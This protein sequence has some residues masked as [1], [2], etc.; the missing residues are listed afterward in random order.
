MNVSY[1]WLKSLVPIDWSPEEL[2]ERLTAVGLSV[3]QVE[4]FNKG[5]KNVVVGEV[6]SVKEHPDE[7]KTKWHVLEVNNGK[8]ILTI[9]CGAPNVAVGIKVALAQV[10]AELPGGINLGAVDKGGVVSNGMLCST[11][12]LQLPEGLAT[13]ESDGGIFILPEECKVGDDLVEALNLDDAIL[14][15]E[16]TPNRADCLSVI[17]IAREVAAISGKPLNLPE[18]KLP[19][20]VKDIKDLA[21]IEVLDNDLCPRYTG[22]L[23]LDVKIGPSPYWMRQRLAAAGIR[24]ISNIVDISNYVMLE[25][26]Q[27]SHTFDYDDIA[28][29]KIIVRRAAKDEKIV[30]LDEA[31]RELDEEML[32]ICDG[33]KAVGI[34]GVMGGLNSEIKDTTKN[35]LIE[36]AYFYPKS[37]RQTY[38]KLGLPSEA[39]SRFEKGIDMEAAERA[40]ERICQLICELAGGTLVD[41]TLDSYQGEFVMPQVSLDYNRCNATL[42]LEIPEPEIDAIIESLDFAYEKIQGGV[43][44]TIPF[45]RQDITREV[46]LIEEVA[47]L[48]GYDKIPTTLP[49][50]TLT[51]GKKTFGQKI[52]DKVKDALTGLG[53]SEIIT[54]SFT[55]KKNYD[56]LTLAQDDE[57]RKSVEVMNPFSDEQGVMRT[58]LLPAILTVASRNMNRKNT[59][60]ALFETAHVFKPLDGEILPEERIH[61]VALISGEFSQGWT[62][63]TQEMDFFYMKGVADTLL[64]KLGIKTWTVE[65]PKNQP[66]LHPGRS[67]QIVIDD[68]VVGYMGELHPVVQENYDMPE[69]SV[70]LEVDLNSII[71]HIGGIKRYKA[72]SK[73]PG[74]EVDL[75]FVCDKE[76]TAGAIEAIIKEVGG[77]FLTSLNLF[78][79]YQGERILST[80]KSLAYRLKFQAQERTL[81]SEE[82]SETTETIVKELKDRLEVEL[83]S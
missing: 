76:V 23:V 52:E 45:Y 11:S 68:D 59:D 22:K 29:H 83:R 80:K 27:P 35:I 72:V 20:A 69:R 63:E 65:S 79:I 62:G 15:L 43:K 9:V 19:Q 53:F 25:M 7:T 30:T 18:V 31:E 13:A 44:V 67:C 81:T 10:G 3:E 49:S 82:I 6:L 56:L 21:E 34:A 12:E 57:G 14:E 51:E 77:E 58:T 46:D 42:G 5:I 75:A 48:Y 36:C 32:L 26:N 47:R 55:N 41:G 64:A 38:R 2:A 28:D 78:D 71:S 39:A 8:E 4:Y 60:L 66:F 70:V 37:I 61:T 17:N 73:Y 1:Q 40:S 16:L 54:Y 24:S 50:G 33:A 74:V